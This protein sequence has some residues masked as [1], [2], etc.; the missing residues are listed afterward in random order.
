VHAVSP[1]SAE[2]YSCSASAIRAV[3]A[4]GIAAT[5]PSSPI[6]RAGPSPAIEIGTWHIGRTGTSRSMTAAGRIRRLGG[7]QRP[8][9]R[10][11]EVRSGPARDR[12]LERLERLRSARIGVRGHG[13]H[14]LAGRRRRQMSSDVRIRP[15]RWRHRTGS[16]GVLACG[17]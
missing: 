15:L 1:P 10:A 4:S 12:V 9:E 7:T 5:S 8:H 11:G 6:H 14:P 17:S 16:E 2:R 13:V 3:M